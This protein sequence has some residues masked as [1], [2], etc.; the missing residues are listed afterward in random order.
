MVHF[1]HICAY[2]VEMVK[3]K[4]SEI[5]DKVLVCL[6]NRIKFQHT[7]FLS[8]IWT[9]LTPIGWDK[10]Q[11]GSFAYSSLDYLTE[12]FLVPLQKRYVNSSQKKEELNGMI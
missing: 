1:A 4:Y 2:G 9:L 12:R 10:V 7:E 11:D 6:C 3:G 5:F 8:H